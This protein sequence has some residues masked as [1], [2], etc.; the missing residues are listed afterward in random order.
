M[1]DIAKVTGTLDDAELNFSHSVGTVYKATASIDGSEKDHVAVVTATDSAGNSTTETMVVSISG[2]WTTP[3]TDWYGYT[4][5]DG[6]YHGDRFNTEDFNRI[7]NNLAYLREI[8]VAM[9]QEFSINDLGDDRSKDQYFYADEINQLE[10]NIS[11][12]AANTFKPDVGE[13][14]L[15]TANGKIF[16]YNQ[17]NRIESLILDLFNQL[18]N[19]Y[20][21]RQMLTFNFGIRREVF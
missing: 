20:R 4:D 9:Y 17:L 6:I 15:Y 21:G 18:L 16:D 3:K 14:P 19:Q 5:G 8:A 11:L 7:K 10:E 2:S 1:A 12:I 13:A